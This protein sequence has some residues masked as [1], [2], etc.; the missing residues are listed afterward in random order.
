MTR[1]AA[2]QQE[3]GQVVDGSTWWGVLE[4]ESTPELRWPLSVEVYDRMRRQDAQVASVL[5]AVTLPVRRT[6]WRVDPNGAR[7]EVARLVSEDLGLPLVGQDLVTPTRLRDRFSW[8]DHLRLALLM[9]PLGHAFFEQLY[10]PVGDQLRLRKLSPRPARTIEAVNVATDGGL[11]SI[12]QWGVDRPIP[13]DR[14]VAYVHDLEGGNWIGNSILRTCY[15]NWLIKDRLL[16]VQAQ[17]VERNG[18]GVPLYKGAPNEADLSKGLAMAKA[19]RGGDA[20]GAAVP[21]G[22]DLVLRG[23][24]GDLPD[25]DVPIRYH[26]EQIARAV[27]AHFLNLGTQTGSWALGSTFADFFTLSLQ[28]VAQQ[29]AEVA[30]QHIV[31]D[32]VDV[33]WGEDEPAPRIVFD[34]IGSRHAVTAEAIK[35]LVDSG[36]VIPD[37]GIEEQ[38]R[39]AYGLPLAEGPRPALAPA[40]ASVA[41]EPAGLRP[42]A[43]RKRVRAA[44][45]TTYPTA[46]ELHQRVAEAALKDLFERQ[47][48]DVQATGTLAE[49]WDEELTE[50][51]YTLSRSAAH[52]VATRVTE[53]LGGTVKA[54]VFD[55]SVMDG[56]LLTVAAAS[57]E[58][59]NAATRESLEEEP[60][61]ES[62]EDPVEHTFALLAGASAA[63]Y[64]RSVV[65]TASSFAAKEAGTAAGARL[66][67]WKVNS[68]NPRSTHRAMDG[69]VTD[70]GEKFSNGMRW[71]GDSAGGPGETANCKCSLVLLEDDDG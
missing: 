46:R 68:T 26:D 23:V 38:L 5:R 30:T 25:A 13:V 63:M 19:W 34:E 60:P 32:L 15:K 10:R 49:S 22:A 45:D 44:V 53:D 1:P 56:W 14:L 61:E 52:D 43:A 67:Q 28:S 40:P 57:A 70:I 33:N 4:V 37:E 42:V 41:P 50:L 29:I 3:I 8:V 35:L 48:A 64:A 47:R 59:I 66:K 21:D 69:E 9:L 36:V 2:P 31:E 65:S 24:D 12:K 71:P 39:Q 51:L 18:M 7:P 58:S 11:V 20:A 16:R 6:Q 27:L 54:T 17:T 55:L 62:E